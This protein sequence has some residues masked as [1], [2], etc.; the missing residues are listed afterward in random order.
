MPVTRT[1]FIDTALSGYQSLATQF[2]AD[3][4]NVIL[5]DSASPHTEQIQNWMKD[6]HAGAADINIVSASDGINGSVTS[7]VV[8]IDPGVANVA[9]V[10]AGVPPNAAVVVLDASRDGVQQIHD[11]LAANAGQVAAIDIVT[12]LAGVDIVSH[13]SPGEIML[14]STVLN[15][16][17]LDDYSSQLAAIGSHLSAGADLLLYG[18]DVASGSTGQQFISALA[19]ATGA[20]VAASTGLTGSA[21]AGGDWVLE[22]NTGTIETAALTIAAYDGLLGVSSVS[23][24]KL[25]DDTGKSSSDFITRTPAQTVSGSFAADSAGQQTLYMSFNGGARV[26]VNIDTF[27]KDTRTGTFSTS[28]LQAREGVNSV[29]FFD[30]QNAASAFSTF[31]FT[32]DTRP[33]TSGVALATDSGTPGDR[34]TNNASLNVSALESGASRVIKVDGAVVSQYDASKLLDGQ[35]TVGVADTDVAGNVGNASITFTLDTKAPAPTLALATDSGTPGDRVTSQAA[36][37]FSAAETSATRVV[38]VDG[39]V[40]SNYDPTKLSDGQHTV[41]VTDTDGAGNVGNASITFTLDTQLT[42]PTVALATDS[43]TA[44]DGRTNDASLSFNTADSDAT[45]VIRV[46]GNV[47]NSYDPKGLPD[48]SHTVS[49]TDT[50]VAGNNKSASL[51]F[52]LDTQLS[53]PTVALATDSGT[54]GDG[55]TNDACLSFNAPD[56]DAARVTQVDGHVVSSYDPKALADGSHTVSVTDTDVAGNSKSA[57]VTFTLDTQLSAPTVTLTSDS[58]TAGDRITNNASLSFNTADSDATRVIKVDGNVVSSYDPTR[59]ADGSH[60]VSVTD[61][62]VA[63]NSKSASLTF[64]LDTQLTAPTVALVTDSGTADD[65]V[66]NDASLHFNTADSD[67]ARVI[68][69]DGNIVNNYDPKAL[70][71]GSHTVSVTDTDVAGNSKSASVTFTLDTQLTAPTVALATDSGTAGDGITNDASLRFNAPDSDAARVIEVDGNA[72]SSY[73]PTKL[74]DGSHTVSVTDTDVAGNS[75]S[76]SLTFTVDT[77]LTAPTVALANDSG[78]PGD[79]IS[80]D[81]SLHFNTADSDAARVIEVD[82]HV[83][84]DYDPNKLAD[85]S[86]TVSVT[87]TDVAGNTKSAS[88]TFTLDTRLTA[89]TV[90]LTTDSGTAD[91]GITNNASLS[92]NAP[93]SD[94]ARVIEVDGHVVNSYDPTKLADGSHTVSVTDTDLAGNSKSTSLTFTLDSKGP[95]FTSAAV[96]SVAENIGENQVV[97]RAAA[98]DDHAFAYR[99]DGAD[100]G[101]FDIGADGSVTL[102]DNP[103]YENKDAYVFTVVA[104]DTAGNHAERAVAL[105]ITNVNEA[106]VASTISVSTIENTPISFQLAEH[107]SDPDTGDKLAFALTANT[108][109]LS[110]ASTDPKAPATLINP[111]THAALDL[112]SLTVNATLSADGS[113]ITLT[114]PAELNWLVTNQALRATFSYTVTDSGGLTSQESIELIVNGSTNDK[115]VNLNG[116]NGN[117]TLSGN[118]TNN[119]EDVLLGANGNDILSGFG[120]TDALYGGNGDDKLY[121]GAGIDYLYGDSGNDT[122]DGGTEGDFL[123][124]GKGNDILTGGT[125][126]DK[127]V[128]APQGGSDRILDFN[129]TEGDQLFFA[130]F[131]STPIDAATFLSKYVT[132]TGNDLLIS[133]PGGT[134]IVLVGVPSVS[135]LGGAIGFGMPA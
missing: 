69:V 68:E 16:A 57:S 75:K 24:L 17:N 15:A 67:A 82:G 94:A 72:V 93:D 126:A 86:H 51:A 98:S 52:T 12:G 32:V 79:G 58:G 10:I 124:G 131:F 122:L 90:A 133:L 7:R 3:T 80:N 9:T 33:P 30:K 102:K 120:G 47:V 31:N 8:F 111:V 14:G 64:T 104:T 73:D 18:C 130:D 26:A 39:N 103:N 106:P 25:S 89:P 113:S 19:A 85:G 5:L 49:V 2:G 29:E 101:R 96:A 132:D 42:G 13:G 60:T 134:S 70:N 77:Q 92:L 50:D 114:P 128:F 99:L 55:I 20:D 125:G 87:D 97:Y 107:I 123:F 61:T 53:A 66:T 40:V 91:D 56:S 74:A 117:D 62:D 129:A 21:A 110:W 22:A 112:S 135:A 27:N 63:G 109:T 71:D 37:S 44:G 54:A 11:Y 127:F 59:L 76:T 45:R 83:V 6:N 95:V 36:L 65:G 84:S 115:G 1:V 108:A 38:R 41:G 34:L 28:T 119:A 78:A 88:L 100:A 4:F 35:H 81:A 116:G 46:D 23:L 118:A 43:G 121:G 105:N 48:G